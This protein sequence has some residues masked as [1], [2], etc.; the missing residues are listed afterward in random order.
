MVQG[1]HDLRL[2]HSLF[3][4]GALFEPNYRSV[5]WWLDVDD[6]EEKRLVKGKSS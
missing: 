6:S 4:Q 5:D 3:Q 2:P 1:T